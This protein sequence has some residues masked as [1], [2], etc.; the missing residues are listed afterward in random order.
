MELVTAEIEGAGGV[1]LLVRDHRPAGRW[2]RT[3][4]CV[5]GLGEHGGRYEHFSEWLVERGIRVIMGDLRGHGRSAGT[6]T[7]VLSFDEYPADLGLLWR[8]FQLEKPS[9]VVFGHSMGGLIA[10][11]A[12]QTGAVDPE[13]LILTSPLLGLKLRVSP[14]KRLLGKLLV[15]FL[16]ET[17]F[18]NG[19]DPRN[20]TRDPRF[21]EE[22]RNDPLIVR[23]VT[24]SWFFAMQRAILQAHRDVARISI[25]ILAF[26]G[27]ADETTDGDV[28][29]TWL[30][31]TKSSVC[32]LVSL[33]THVHEVF[34]ESDWRDSMDRMMQW[35][36][37]IKTPTL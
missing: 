24:A 19:L 36:D 7:H 13:A 8:H 18:R 1:R 34:H 6:R 27:M 9:T 35:L 16:P 15:R 32:D 25:P 30:S 26:R 11:R 4:L 23:T 5:H 22:R 20:M 29:S 10:V 28:L 37:Q 12:V 21:A 2:S 31:R 3:F 17:R 14:L 33:P